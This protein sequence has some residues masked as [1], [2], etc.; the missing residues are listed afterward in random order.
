MIKYETVA[1]LTCYTQMFLYCF[2]VRVSFHLFYSFLL[3][4]TGKMMGQGKELSLLRNL[5]AGN[6]L[7]T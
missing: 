3:F 6:A 4:K 2:L 7:I 5:V 1:L